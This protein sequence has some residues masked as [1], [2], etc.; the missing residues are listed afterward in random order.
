MKLK[1]QHVM[2]ATL[3]VT[4]IINRAAPMP[5][6]GKYLLARMH[7]KL[8]PEFK[9]IDAR[10]DEMI[11][12]YNNPQQRPVP[13]AVV[14]AGEPVP[15]EDVP[16]EWQ[17]PLE[18]MPEFTAA[19]KEIGA[20]EIEVDIQPIPLIALSLPNGSDGAIESSELITLGDLVVD[21]AN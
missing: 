16:G 9:T 17:V 7:T 21:T 2:D 4:Q 18:H 1:V 5:Q 11:K 10:R 15:M 6:R 12:A 19:W 14:E 13:G 8:M 3:I 20:E